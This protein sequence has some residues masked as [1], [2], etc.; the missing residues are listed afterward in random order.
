MISAVVLLL[1][2]HFIEIK[3]ECYSCMSNSNW[4][5]YA[6]RIPG[7][8]DLNLTERPPHAPFACSFDPMRVYADKTA[9]YCKGFCYKWASGTILPNGNMEISVLRGCYNRLID[10]DYHESPSDNRCFQTP[11][12]YSHRAQVEY[13]ME[14]FCKG[15]M[16]NNSP[17]SFVN[18][19]IWPIL[20]FFRL[21]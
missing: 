3:G 9:V 8:K 4:S 13:K 17:V 12:D 15:F 19:M 7:L 21:I 20:L 10:E 5:Y 6:E 14:C 11:D 18:L 1:I 16:C 2:L